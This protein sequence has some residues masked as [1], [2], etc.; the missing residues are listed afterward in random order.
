[1]QGSTTCARLHKANTLSKPC[2]D[3]IPVAKRKAI[4]AEANLLAAERNLKISMPFKTN[5][6]FPERKSV[7]EE[8]LK[9]WL[10]QLGLDYGR[11]CLRWFDEVLGIMYLS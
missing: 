1:M 11:L 2:A 8:K 4:E 3:K 10:C 9:T 5:P 7:Y 6:S